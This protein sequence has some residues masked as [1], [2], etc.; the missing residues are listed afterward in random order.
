M[1]KVTLL[2]PATVA[3]ITASFISIAQYKCESSVQINRKVALT[4][5]LYRHSNGMVP[6]SDLLSPDI[7]PGEIPV[8]PKEDIRV[9]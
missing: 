7:V 3:A 8:H 4:S 1:V 9:L 6:L 2:V 5:T